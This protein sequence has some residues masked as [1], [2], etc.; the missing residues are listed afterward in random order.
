MFDVTDKVT[1]GVSYRSK[2]SMKVNEGHATLNYANENELKQMI[3]LVNPILTNIG[4]PA[5]GIP[6]LDAGT[7]EAALPLPSNLNV[8]VSF[9]PSDRLLLSG[10]VQFVGWSAYKEL[11]VQFSQEVLNGYSIKA[12]KNYQNTRI[13]RIGSQFAAT[14]RLDLRLGFYLDESPVKKDFLNPETP[15]MTKLGSTIGLSFRPVDKFSVDLSCQYI[16]GFG[17]DGSYPL[18]ASGDTFGGHY[19]VHALTP[20]IGVSYAF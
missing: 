1:V 10:E 2:V 6:P 4:Q 17:R 16:T 14:G 11:D 15:S 7:F 12:E 8:G 9:K 20:S 5:I 18:N 3:G 13:Y 19:E